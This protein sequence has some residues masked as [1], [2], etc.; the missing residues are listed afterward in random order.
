MMHGLNTL[1]VYKDGTVDVVGVDMGAKVTLHDLSPKRIVIKR[2][3]FTFTQN[4]GR[5]F[6]E[7]AELSIGKVVTI[8]KPTAGNKLE[9]RG[10]IAIVS[11]THEADVRIK[12][13][14]EAL[15]VAKLLAGH[16]MNVTFDEKVGA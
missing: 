16:V 3:G 5:R 4:F 13:D 2:D 1:H 12:P 15:T 11:C 7:P 10:V 9:E 6:Y 14:K 8:T